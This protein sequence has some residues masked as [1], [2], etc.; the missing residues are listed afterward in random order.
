MG[1]YVDVHHSQPTFTAFQ[2]EDELKLDVEV[3][4]GLPS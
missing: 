2:L 4:V 1:I 3:E